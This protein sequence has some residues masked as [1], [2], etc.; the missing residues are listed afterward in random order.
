MAGDVPAV[1]PDG[2]LLFGVVVPPPLVEKVLSRFRAVLGELAEQLGAL[3][4][5]V[6]SPVA[7]S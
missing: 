5:S 7:S 2:V 6:I 1:L 4:G 3:T